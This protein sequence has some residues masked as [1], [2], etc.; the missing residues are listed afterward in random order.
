VRVVL[1]VRPDSVDAL[2]DALR[3]LRNR[4]VREMEPSLDLWTRWSRD[5]MARLERAVAGG[6]DVW[7]ESLPDISV[8]WFDEK[9]A[10]LA[11]LPL[12]RCARCGFGRGEIA[13]APSG[14]VYPCERLVGEDGAA[15]QATARQLGPAP[16]ERETSA[17]RDVCDNCAIRHLCS[18]FCRCSNYVRTGHVDRPDR[19]L[20]TLNRACVHETARVLRARCAPHRPHVG[21]GSL[22]AARPAT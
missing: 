22:A 6:A 7:G 11:G 19:L 3:F 21:A 1:V 20:C 16:A 17:E 8:S 14:R 12:P 5:D 15:A 9:A 4:G 10:G 2:P 13:V 18:T